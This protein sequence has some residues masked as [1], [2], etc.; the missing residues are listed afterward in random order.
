MKKLLSL[1]AFYLM[2][3]AGFAAAE[4]PTAASAAAQEKQSNI[5]VHIDSVEYTNPIHLWYPYTDYWYFQ[6]PMFEEVA[7]SKLNEAYAETTMCEAAQ[8]GKVLLWL[9]PKMFYNPQVNM[10]YGKV[11]ANAYTGMGE[12]FATY[13]AESGVWGIFNQQNETRIRQSYE[14]AVDGL[15][16]KLKA[17]VNFQSK[18]DKATASNKGASTPCSMIT[19]LPTTR[20]R[21]MPF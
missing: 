6:G 15:I 12:H 2:L 9:K 1:F 19:L 16:E 13:E 8:Y 18:L 21:A 20:I 5:V 7:I 17:D 3:N 10:F 11:T 14:M 4:E